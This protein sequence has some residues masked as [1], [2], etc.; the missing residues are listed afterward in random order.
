MP[1]AREG[2]NKGL[3][4]G[5]EWKKQSQ[6]AFGGSSL[7]VFLNL[8]KMQ[9]DCK[10]ATGNARPGRRTLVYGKGFALIELG[11]GPDGAGLMGLG[12]GSWSVRLSMIF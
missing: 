12:P 7:A 4:D 5:H 11:L 3:G 2:S 1:P 6:C 9:L 10:D 8:K